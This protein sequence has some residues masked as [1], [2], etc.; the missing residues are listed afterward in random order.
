MESAI[1]VEGFNYLYAQYGIKIINFIGDGDS[2]VFFSIQTQVPY[3]KQ[4]KKFECM[5]HIMKNLHSHLLD[6]K[7]NNK[8][9]RV[10][11]KND[12]D[13]IIA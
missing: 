7:S 2:N 6:I 13:H 4:V 10:F 3:G 9:Q 1:V 11:T 12:I 5:N 8:L